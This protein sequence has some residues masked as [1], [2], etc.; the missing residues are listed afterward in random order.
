MSTEKEIYSEL[1]EGTETFIRWLNLWYAGNPVLSLFDF[2][3]V[4]FVPEEKSF[5]FLHKQL[6]LNLQAA[7]ITKRR[8]AY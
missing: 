3:L 1:R 5:S 8:K 2:E 4:K 7:K 6:W